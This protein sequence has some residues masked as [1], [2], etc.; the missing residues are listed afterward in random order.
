MAH[1]PLLSI[2]ERAAREVAATDDDV[3]GE[4]VSTRR[5]FLIGAA[6]AG[7]AAA[8][9][10]LGEPAPTAAAATERIVVVGAGLAGLTCAYELR[11]AGH[12]AEIHDAHPDRLGGRVWSDRQTFAAGQI[13]EHGGELIDQGHTQ[14]RQ[15]CKSLGLQ[16]DNLLA[17]EQNGTEPMFWFDSAPYSYAEATDDVK[18][19]WQK[20]KSDVQAASYPTLYNISTERGRELDSMSIIDWIEESVPGGMT[21]RLGQ[22]LDVAY[23]IEYGAECAEQSSLN[24]LYL[25]GYSGQG[26]LRV[27]GPSNEKYHV[28]GGNDQIVDGLASLL[29][30]QIVSGSA[31]TRITR[32]ADDGYELTFRR[33]GRSV[34]QTADRVV[35]AL[36]FAV[37]RTLDYGRAGFSDRKVQAIREQ[38]MGTNSKLN[39]QFV[40]RHWRTL[41]G[42]GDTYADTGYQAT[43]EVTRSQP[44]AE[45]ILVDYTGGLIGASFG[46]GTPDERAQIFATQIE[47]LFPGIATKLNGRATV[48]F[49]PASPYQRGSYSYWKVGQYQAFAG[50]ERERSGRCHFAGEHTSVDFQGYLNGAVE[51][52][53]RAAA[54]ILAD[55]KSS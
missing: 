48:D 19:I 51:S 28:R 20:I 40:D 2:F 9:W 47:P 39:V 24:L 13:A 54:E 6:A 4:P 36:P 1:T 23:N 46:T 37:L 41:G 17:A 14:I 15:L 16:L 30:G 25:L 12:V 7:A 3:A 42:N 49:W 43:W 38:G 52:G 22:L 5:G 26:Q 53:Q 11:K 44:G 34:T 27:F 31:L 10:R 32:R 21:S 55:H 35:L 33:N 29:G 50:V 45:G 18:S 8:T